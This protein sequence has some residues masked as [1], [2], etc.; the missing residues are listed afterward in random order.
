MKGFPVKEHFTYRNVSKQRFSRDNLNAVNNWS[1]GENISTQNNTFSVNLLKGN[2]ETP[3]SLIVYQAEGSGIRIR[4]ENDPSIE[5]YKRFDLSKEELVIDQNAI[6]THSPMTYAKDGG[7]ITLQFADNEQISITSQPLT[8]TFSRNNEK[9]IIVNAEKHL[10]YEYGNS[11]VPQENHLLIYRDPIPHGAS[12]VATDFTFLGESVHLSGLCERASPLNLSDTVDPIRLFNTDAFKYKYDNPIH[13]Y[14]SVPFVMSHN[15]Q[16]TTGLFWMNSSDTYA[17]IKTTEIGRNLHLISETGFLDFLLF[18][19]SF[20]DIMRKFTRITGRPLMP[21]IFSLGYHQCKWGYK[22]QAEVEKVMSELDRVGIPYDAIWLDVDHLEGKAPFQV[23]RKTFPHIEETID[24]LKQDERYLIR[25]CDPHFPVKGN[26]KQYTEALQQNF[27]IKEPSGTPYTGACWPGKCSWPDFLNPLCRDWYS[28]QYHYSEDNQSPNVFIWNDMNEPSIFASDQGTFPKKLIHYNGTE[29]RDTHNIYGL[30]NT[31]ATYK[32]LLERDENIR[33]RPFILTRSFY[34]GSQ[35]YA[36]IWTGDNTGSWEHLSIS[37]DMIM[38][39]GLC[40]MPFVGAD[41]GGFFNSSPGDLIA[42]W[43]QVGSWCY[44]FFREHCVTNASYR[45]PYLFNGEIFDAMK[46]AV[47]DRYRMLSYF[48]TESYKTHIT[49]AP[50]IKPLWAIFPEVDQMHTLRNQ[51]IVGDS[52]LVAPVISKEAK[53]LT[54][55]KPPGVWYSIWNGI[56]LNE[57][58]NN[59]NVGML[60]IPIY[61]RG[62][63]IIPVYKEIGKSALL[64]MTKPLMLIIA[65]DENLKAEG[66]MFLDDG[67]TFDYINKKCIYCKFT[68][69]NGKLKS[70]KIDAEYI[71]PEMYSET[72]ITALRIYGM[73][74]SAN[75]NGAEATYENG[76]LTV[77]GLRLKVASEWELT[78]DE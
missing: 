34:A 56:V 33:Y 25:L 19:G 64:T 68:F 20:S 31:A 38:S 73:R 62:G 40:G 47:I 6:N 8:I 59:I 23:N 1:L 75:V 50:L 76:V 35:K 27:L 37:L 9:I 48:Y 74:N 41:V 4:V 67:K 5:N 71:A 49:G 15:T 32:G 53:T 66:E 55:T 65:L 61:L 7:E 24:K 26:H 70:Q 28:Q 3:L 63:R 46:N 17:S 36:F 29:T 57:N 2:T 72:L 44:T 52:I 14:G 22:S 16:H 51:V 43:Y 39:C 69:D 78:F 77:E 11:P 30:L 42:R 21:P 45:E 58:N 54:V 60:D 10:V 18:S 13:I 12:A